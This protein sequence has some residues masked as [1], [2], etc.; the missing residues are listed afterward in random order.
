MEACRRLIPDLQTRDFW[1]RMPKYSTP[2]DPAGHGGILT[3]LGKLGNRQS[4]FRTQNGLLSW[5]SRY[6]TLAMKDAILSQ[7]SNEQKA[8][9]STEG[10][11]GLSKNQLKAVL[12][13][14][15]GSA[16]SISK[17]RYHDERKRRAREAAGATEEEREEEEMD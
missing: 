10:F 15:K 9:N 4:R 13:K 16:S 6:G 14:S 12:A 17:R 3:K 7:L 1:A 11:V 5:Q 8:N 2:P